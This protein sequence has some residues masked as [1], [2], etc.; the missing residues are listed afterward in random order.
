[1]K[2]RLV[3]LDDSWAA[4]ASQDHATTEEKQSV[5]N[6]PR[7]QRHR[8]NSPSYLLYRPTS[9]PRP[10]GAVRTRSLETKTL[11]IATSGGSRCQEKS[12]SSPRR[13]CGKHVE[14]LWTG[15]A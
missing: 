8:T 12:F 5:G 14:K 11:K 7:P 15:P 13:S 10:S 1:M 3:H 4:R 2:F 9:L 6:R